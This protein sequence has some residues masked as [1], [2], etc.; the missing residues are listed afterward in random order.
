[1]HRAATDGG[2]WRNNVTSSTS[3]STKACPRVPVAGAVVRTHDAATQKS[4]TRCART[5]WRARARGDKLGDQRENLSPD[6]G[7][8]MFWQS[9][10]SL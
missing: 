2:R 7:D 4:D 8:T 6:G 5:R 9:V 10:L 3:V 1:M